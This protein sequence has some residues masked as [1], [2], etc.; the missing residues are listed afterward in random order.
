MEKYKSKFSEALTPTSE[1]ADLDQIQYF[2]DSEKVIEF[3]PIPS[4]E[5][6][7]DSIRK[8]IDFPFIAETDI[9]EAYAKMIV[10]GKTHYM[11]YFPSSTTP[12]DFNILRKLVEM[13]GKGKLEK[14]IVLIPKSF[15]PGEY[16]NWS[17]TN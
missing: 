7:V 3:F 1:M 13:T 15:A 16:K 5:G 2:I 17:G 6:I 4:S 10:H 14:V 9:F 12:R 8:E 11:L